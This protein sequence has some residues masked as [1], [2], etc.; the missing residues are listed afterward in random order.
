MTEFKG[1]GTPGELE[2]TSW[3]FELSFSQVTVWN[4]VKNIFLHDVRISYTGTQGI[5]GDLYIYEYAVGLVK[6]MCTLLK[7]FQSVAC[8]YC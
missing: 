6:Y 4:P 8:W 5:F 3:K 1:R 7:T 2:G